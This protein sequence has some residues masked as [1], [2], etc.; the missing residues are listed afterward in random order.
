MVQT[1]DGNFV[2][3]IEK[4]EPAFATQILHHCSQ[5][6]RSTTSPDTDLD[7]IP[8]SVKGIPESG[9]LHH[10]NEEIIRQQRISWSLGQAI[11]DIVDRSNVCRHRD[12]LNQIKHLT[13][14]LQFRIHFTCY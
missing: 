14:T 5:E 12:R 10:G 13:A 1:L 4:M 3:G 6:E 9:I 11:P 7:P 2:K 8:F